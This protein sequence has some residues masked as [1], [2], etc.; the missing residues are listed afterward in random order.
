MAEA[1]DATKAAIRALME[2]HGIG[3]FSYEDADGA[4]LIAEPADAGADAV[5]AEV[6][7]IV[8][9]RHPAAGQVAHDPK[10]Q[11][12]SGIGFYLKIGP[13]LVPVAASGA[14]TP[15]AADGSIVG[16]GSRIG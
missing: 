1:S 2:R 13:L 12:R 9:H 4:I 10:D 8:C 5:L 11:G 16:Y 7:A 6:P 15:T 3:L 14:G